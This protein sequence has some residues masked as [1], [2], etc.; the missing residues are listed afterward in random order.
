VDA[1]DV[2]RLPSPG[3]GKSGARLSDGRICELAGDHVDAAAA[4]LEETG[5]VDRPALERRLREILA[6]EVGPEA[7]ETEFARIMVAL[8]AF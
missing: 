6:A 5:D 2:E 8:E 4:Q 1:T 3:S 7:V